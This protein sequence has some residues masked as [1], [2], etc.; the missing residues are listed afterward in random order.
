MKVNNAIKKLEGL[1]YDVTKEFER[2]DYTAYGKGLRKITFKAGQD[3]DIGCIIV[4][5]KNF[6]TLGGAIKRASI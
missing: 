2:E 6:T 5:I 3:G 4:G 1:G